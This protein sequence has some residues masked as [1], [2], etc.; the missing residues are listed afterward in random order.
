MD[1]LDRMIEEALSAEDRDI[2]D[3]TAEKGWFQQSFDLFRGKNGWVAWV[4]MVTQTALFI[5]GAWCAVRFYGATE[6]LPALRWGIS[7]AVLLILATSL[8]L[9]L[10]PQ[11]QADRVLREMRRLE[12]MLAKRDH[13]S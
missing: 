6:V 8:K 12:L 4:L 7:G 10:M 11:I 5:A 13:L 3:A 2:L 9:S 1:K